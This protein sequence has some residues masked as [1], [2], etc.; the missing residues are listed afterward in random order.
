MVDIITANNGIVDKY[1]GD[2]IMAFY[3]APLASEN[4]ALLCV[5]SAL[6]MIDALDEFNRQQT[7]EGKVNF[8]IGVG[9]NYGE[10]T[11]GNIGSEKKMD[12]TVIGDTVN[13]ASRLES[14]TKKY[15]EQIVFSEFVYQHVGRYL[16]CRLLDK[17]AVKGKTKGV[18]L[19]TV[20]REIT[21]QEKI[22]WA[23]YHSGLNAY[24]DRDFRAA[25][26]HFQNTLSHL[27]EDYMAKEM[28]SRSVEYQKDPPPIDWEGVEIL[29]EK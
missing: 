8:Q 26:G 4:D 29:H 11:V 27:P 1:I 7:L 6:G 12:Y 18:G 22:G 23:H 13:L 14:L 2:A 28:L 3:G 20:R 21:E 24:Y 9:I 19:Y 15:H 25:M 10:V 17:V 5:N 16:Y